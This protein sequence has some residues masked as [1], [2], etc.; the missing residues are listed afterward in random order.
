MGKCL[1]GFRRRRFRVVTRRIECRSRE[2]PDLDPFRAGTQGF[3]RPQRRVVPVGHLPELGIDGAG[4]VPHLPRDQAFLDTEHGQL[5]MGVEVVGKVVS[6]ALLL[7]GIA[8]RLA[9]IVL[10][11]RMQVRALPTLLRAATKGEKIAPSELVPA[12]ADLPVKVFLPPAIGLIVV[13]TAYVPVAAVLGWNRAANLTS[14]GWA[15]PSAESLEVVLEHWIESYVMVGITLIL[16]GIGLWLLAI[17]RSLGLQRERFLGSLA[18][19]T[20]TKPMPAP[21]P[22][23]MVK[24]IRGLLAVGLGVTVV[25]L[26][27]TGVWIGAGLEAVATETPGAILAD[28]QWEAFVK[29]FKFAGMG[30]VFLDIGLALNV[31]VVNLQLLAWVL[32]GV[33]ARFA[34]VARGRTPKPLE[35]SSVNPMSLVPKKL[36]LGILA[37]W[38]VVVTATIPL[39]WPLRIGTF[40]VFLGANLAS[41]VAAQTAFSLEQFL[42]HLILPYKLAG[43]AIILFSIGRYF[44]TIVGSVKAR[45][46]IVAEGVSSVA[47]YVGQSR[48]T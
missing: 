29:P 31:I 44:T 7:F 4:S 10:N 33:F 1:H 3:V 13:L 43:V 35:M 39:A 41:N 18:E 8:A 47:E 21:A 27:L 30:L 25:S 5:E 34:D 14:A 46:T 6:T 16:F 12:R 40:D 37:G 28:H 45:K 19:A 11:L 9:T 26:V 22:P 42:E 38:L 20:D 32:P 36:F 48:P 2:P 17:I 15:T 24:M 23:R